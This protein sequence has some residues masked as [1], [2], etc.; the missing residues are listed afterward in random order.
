MT[1]SGLR[2]A[3]AGELEAFDSKGHKHADI[4]DAAFQIQITYRKAGYA[5]AKVDYKIEITNGLTTV[6]FIIYEGPRVTIRDIA[7]TGN[8]AFDNKYLSAYLEKH[9]TGLTGGGDLVFVR[10]KVDTAVQEIRQRYIT[11]GFLDV[12]IETPNFEFTPER[13]H[14][15]ISVSIKEGFQY[16]IHEINLQGDLIVDAAEALALF[17]TEMIG[18]PYFNRKKL[19]VKAKIQEVFGNLGYPDALVT[20][21]ERMNNET[22]SVSLD[23][24]IISGPLVILSAIDVQGNERTQKEFILD[25]IHLKPG[26]RY[27][28]NL[29]KES[30]QQLYKTGIFKKV[31]FILEKTKAPEK[32]V[33]VISV[34]EALSKEVFLE[35]GWGS[36][37]KLRLR[38]GFKEKNLW[39]IGKIFSSEVSLSLLAQLLELR[40]T[41]PFFF[42]YDTRADITGF[43]NHRVEPS[44]TRRDLGT[45]LSLTKDLTDNLSGTIGYTLRTTDLSDIDQTFEEEGAEDNYDFASLSAQATYDTRDDL[46]FPTSGQRFAFSAEHADDFLGGDLTFTQF[47]AGYRIFYHLAKRTILACRFT[48]GLIITGRDQVTLPL[49]ERFFNGGENTVRSFKEGELGPRKTDNDP[50]GGYGFNVLNIELR[51]R[52]VGKLI[53]TLFFDCGNISPNRTRLEAGKPPYENSSEVLSDTLDDFFSG[54]RPSIGFGLQYLLPVGPARIDFAFNP[55]SDPKR[56]ED[57]FVFHFSIGAAF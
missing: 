40:L 26:D 25:R 42:N 47:T 9:R 10:S 30:F 11:E 18:K 31:D 21:V 3:A 57:F 19:I 37:E 28:L 5:F 44:F 23:A 32:R 48:S 14:V 15:D 46:F 54:F 51:Q 1:D 2:R 13:T 38:L 6:T 33:M 24:T 43:F 39:G 55:D 45:K 53:G 41:D 16:R 12:D 52:L 22:G 35:P 49:S 8:L 50:A 34:K 29:Q 17:K 56:N 20:V 27:N 36:Y 4:D 7:F